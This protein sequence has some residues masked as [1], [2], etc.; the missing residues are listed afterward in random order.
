[1]VC[2]QQSAAVGVELFQIERL[3][4]MS[5]NTISDMYIDADMFPTLV[6]L[7]MSY[8]DWRASAT[9]GIVFAAS[10]V[11]EESAAMYSIP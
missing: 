9:N 11:G 10:Q 3:N 2:A 7:S 6:L 1:M 8:H 4:Q 5:I